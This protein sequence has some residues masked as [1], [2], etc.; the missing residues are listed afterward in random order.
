MMTTS[1]RLACWVCR[2]S[3]GDLR[4]FYWTVYVPEGGV[5]VPRQVRVHSHPECFRAFH[6]V[7]ERYRFWS[8]SQHTVPDGISLKEPIE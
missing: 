4:R 8:G 1:K 7:D 2:Y 5:L 3:V 6:Q